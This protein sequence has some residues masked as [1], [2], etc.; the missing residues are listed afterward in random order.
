[1]IFVI[2]LE[3]FC[4]LFDGG[5]W[6][7][8]KFIYDRNARLAAFE[9]EQKDQIDVLNI[10]D[11]LSTTS[12]APMELYRDYGY[13]SYNLGQDLQTPVESYY[14]LKTAL[15]TQ[16]IKVVLYEAHNL[17]SGTPGYEFP[18][19]LLS[20]RLKTDFPFLRF[21]YVWL[22]YWKPRSI[23]HYFKGFLV[24]DGHDGYTGGEYYDWSSTEHHW[25]ND[26]YVAVFKKTVELCRRKGITLVLYSAPSPVCYYTISYHNTLVDLAKE[27]GVVYMEKGIDALSAFLGIVSAGGC[28]CMLAP[29]LPEKRLGQILDVLDAKLVL[30]TSDRKARADEIFPE[31]T[32]L[33]VEKMIHAEINEAALL[34][35]REQTIDTDPLYINFTSG[36]TG[37]PKGIAVAH[38]S[39]IDFIEHFTP[40]FGIGSDDVIANQAPF[41]FDVSVKDIYS[42]LQTGATL[43]VVPRKLFS[44]PAPLLDYLCDNRV[45]TLI[46]AVSALCLITT[47]HGLEYKTPYSVRRVLFSGEVMP[48]KHL[49]QWRSHLPNATFVNLYGPTEIT[50]NCTYHILDPDRDYSEGVPIGKSFP[51]ED[52]FLL[53]DGDK[54]IT[55]PGVVGRIIVRGTALALGYYRLD[56][57]TAASFIQNPL[58]SSYPEPVYVTGDLGRYDENGDLVFCGRTDNQIK[59]LGHRIELEE[60]ERNIYQI[61]GVDRCFCVFENEKFGR[62]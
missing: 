16:P 13:T 52:V 32:V 29:E 10:G 35:V 47:F 18:E 58:H 19:S 54:K 43:V 6:F 28:Y 14:A 61:D 38:R 15:K 17:F 7:E 31:V 11:S 30:T 49:K 21:H 39:V 27:V 46:W 50:C 4:V 44:A 2:L 45:T 48:Y 40:L 37:I 24:N 5:Y 20:E 57:K 53:D 12:L 9:L 60:I 23:R 22:K 56:D 55:E 1:M 25:I 42:A 51:N 8:K 3:I 36:S 34:R 41:D 62:G 59:Y 33:S 26:N